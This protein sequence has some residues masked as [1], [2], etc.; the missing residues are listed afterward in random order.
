[1]SKWVKRNTQ[2]KAAQKIKRAANKR[3]RGL[4]LSMAGGGIAYPSVVSK[5]EHRE[6]ARKYM[7]LLMGVSPAETPE[8]HVKRKRAVKTHTYRAAGTEHG[9]QGR[10]RRP[11][12]E[13]VKYGR[14]YLGQSLFKW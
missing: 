13:S 6:S 1:M 4:G 14:P 12:K 7:D 3:I 10:F 9:R 5:K 2:G 11:V 8:E